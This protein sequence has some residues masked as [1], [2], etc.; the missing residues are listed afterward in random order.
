MRSLLQ[1]LAA[2]FRLGVALRRAAYRQGWLKTRRLSRPVVS[3][4]NLT[5]GG[6]AKTPMV[7]WIAARLLGRGWKPA[8]LTRGYGRRAG[9][10]I[11]A[12]APGPARAP[13][14]IE[15]GDEPALLARAL[16]EVPIIV[17]ADRYRA[18]RLA[19]ERFNVDAHI[20]DDG[21]QHLALARDLD[22]V[23]LDVTQEFSER[24]LLPAGKLREPS[25]ALERA[26]IVVLTRVDLG[27]PRPI[28]DLVARTNPQAKVFH[29]TTGL[30]S[31]AELETGRRCPAETFQGKPVVAFCGIGNPR[32]FFADLKKWRFTTVEE[33]VFP[34]HTA[35][36]SAD[37]ERI[38]ARARKAGAA[39][40]LTTEKDAMNFPSPWRSE[41][42]LL[43]CMIQ[44]AV[45][46][47]EAFEAELLARLEARRVTA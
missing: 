3:V 29:S 31:L 22:V 45:R 23:L 25:T 43:A 42:P 18:G 39:A 5:V 14:A 17:C 4:G 41:L 10:E 20:L 47:A 35:Y 2:G 11:I 19:E 12:L 6:S 38:A 36:T 46:E 1:P 27:D 34:D 8:V 30:C 40:L 21:F 9:G 28:E 15:V 7:A 13:K 37:L 32:A 44:L 33:F 26:H 24:A 16:P